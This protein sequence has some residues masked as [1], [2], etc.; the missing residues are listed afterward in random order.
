MNRLFEP[1][2]MIH[3]NDPSQKNDS[4]TDRT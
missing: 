4:L 3:L 2:Q 1:D